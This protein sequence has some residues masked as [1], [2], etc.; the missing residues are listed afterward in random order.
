MISCDPA[1]CH[2]LSLSSPA[3]PPDH[4][5]S[6]SLPLVKLTSSSSAVTAPARSLFV[7]EVWPQAA[8][9]ERVISPLGDRMSPQACGGSIAKTRHQGKGSQGQDG[10][11]PDI[12]SDY[13][14][15]FPLSTHE[16]ITSPRPAHQAVKMFLTGASCSYPRNAGLLTA[17]VSSEVFKAAQ[18]ALLYL[19]PFTLLPLLTMAYLKVSLHVAQTRNVITRSIDRVI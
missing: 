16:S 5:S 14:Q 13:I 18:P 11:D 3:N 2:T 1:A 8:W 4:A 17:T 10:R 15:M 6:V 19:V 9:C 12:D 7:R